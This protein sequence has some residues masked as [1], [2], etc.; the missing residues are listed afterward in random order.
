MSTRRLA[1]A[2]DGDDMRKD[3]ALYRMDFSQL[4][5]EIESL[6]RNDFASLKDENARLASELEKYKQKLRED[7]ARLHSSTKLELNLERGKMWDD[8][9]E[10]FGTL[11]ETET[12]IEQEAGMIKANLSQVKYDTMRTLLSTFN[13]RPSYSF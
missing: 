11:K 7:L 5:S 3:N 10:L 1:L 12:K 4:R 9:A 13:C 6:E 2:F 8:R